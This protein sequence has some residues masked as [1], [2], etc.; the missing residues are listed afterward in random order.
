[1]VIAFDYNAP[2][3][4]KFLESRLSFSIRLYINLDFGALIF[5]FFTININFTN[6]YFVN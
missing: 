1:M 5:N 6:I 3:W 2:K 4:A